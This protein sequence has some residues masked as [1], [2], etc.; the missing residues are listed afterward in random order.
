[1]SYSVFFR[2]LSKSF[3]TA[4]VFCLGSSP[5]Y[6]ASYFYFSAGNN[7][8]NAAHQFTKSTYYITDASDTS[9]LNSATETNHI[10]TGVIG[11]GVSAGLGHKIDFEPYYIAFEI[12]SS[13]T[14][15]QFSGDTEVSTVFED[16]ISS[17][18]ATPIVL[19]QVQ[20]KFNNPIIA[21]VKFGYHISK[22]MSLSLGLGLQSASYT[23]S[24]EY[25]RLTNDGATVSDSSTTT[26]LDINQNTRR[27]R[28][29]AGMDY[30]VT[31]YTIWYVEAA[32]AVAQKAIEK[33]EDETPTTAVTG[34]TYNIDTAT[35][36]PKISEVR[37]GLKYLV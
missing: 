29:S 13:T 25:P 32:Y 18:T 10:N 4:V 37:F 27:M 26:T 11:L 30:A 17:S 24:Y 6:A 1:M 35:V 12:G 19:A 33:T 15:T 21:Q 2:F 7:A 5:L 16:G 3:F 20:E 34:A 9:S 28:I 36:K 23:S 31:P 22:R 14:P 8:Y